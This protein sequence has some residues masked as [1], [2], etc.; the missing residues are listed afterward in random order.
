MKKDIPEWVL[1]HKKKGIDIRFINNNYYAYKRHSVWDSEKKRAKTI[2]DEYIGK[3][4]EGGIT[5][6][7][8]QRLMQDICKANIKEYGASKLIVNLNK[9]LI[10]ELKEIYPEL[11]EYIFSLATERLFYSSPL[12]NMQTHFNCSYLSDEFPKIN[13]SPKNASEILKYIGLDREKIVNLLKKLM[14][15]TEHLIV[16]LTAIYS[17]AENSTYPAKGYNSHN[18]YLPQVNMLL[19][20]SKDKN[21]PIYFRLLPGSI[22]DINSIK[23]TLEESEINNAVFVGDKAFYSESNVDSIKKFVSK[24]ILPIRRNL[25]MIDYT[26]TKNPTKKYFDGYFFFE[27]RV[28]WHKEI[29]QGENRIIL[30]L[31]ESLKLSE[32]NGFLQRLE[33]KNSI[34]TIEDYHEKECTFGTIAIITNT[35]YPAEEIYSYLKSRL[36]IEAAFDTFK[37]TLEADRTYM[38]TDQH[39]Q[40][41]CFINFISLYLYYSIYGIL[42]SNKLIKKFSPK[43]VI[44]HFSKVHKIKLNG[45]EI[46]TEYPRTVKNLIEKMKLDKNV[47]ILE[48]N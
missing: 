28:I 2:T 23:L 37:N 3:I 27:K 21:K 32:Q 35:N 36:H 13:L 15:G 9:D 20:F 29:N 26:P 10:S 16:D 41:W 30:F 12:K 34:L 6:S 1:K 47:L 43:D 42:I 25:T 4:S 19:L 45:K 38:R 46:V 14:I 7:K 31:D 44:L 11:W 8:H 40:G 17:Q 5:K 18:E 22:V 24:Y 33:S 48:K 39:L